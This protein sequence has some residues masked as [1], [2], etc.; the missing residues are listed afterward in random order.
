M[1]PVAGKWIEKGVPKE[2]EIEDGTISVDA[3]ISAIAFCPE[4]AIKC[5]V[6]CT[7]NMENK[8]F[9]LNKVLPQV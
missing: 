5:L 2:N 8:A 4:A 1:D 6:H 3:A 7:K 9:I